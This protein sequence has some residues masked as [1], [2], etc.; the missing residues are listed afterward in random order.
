MISH[1]LLIYVNTRNGNT[2]REVNVLCEVFDSDAPVVRVAHQQEALGI[3]ISDHSSTTPLSSSRAWLL[4]PVWRGTINGSAQHS[5][6][7]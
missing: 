3:R 5:K 1:E 6:C 7:M 4:E 2:T